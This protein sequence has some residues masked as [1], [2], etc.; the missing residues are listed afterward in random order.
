MAK[1]ICLRAVEAADRYDSPVGKAAAYWNA[2]LVWKL[3]NAHVYVKLRA[4]D[5]AGTVVETRRGDYDGSIDTSTTFNWSFAENLDVQ[6][7]VCEEKGGI[8]PDD[9]TLIFEI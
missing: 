8:I 1:R 4:F 7:K 5:S 9:C 2:S 3:N 6:I